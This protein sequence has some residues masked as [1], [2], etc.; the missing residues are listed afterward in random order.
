MLVTPEASTP[1]TPTSRRPRRPNARPK[2]ER[3]RVLVG[4]RRPEVVGAAAGRCCGGGGGCRA[5]VC[6]DGGE[7]EPE[8]VVET[9]AAL[10]DVA[11]DNAGRRAHVSSAGRD[12]DGVV[13]CWGGWAFVC[14]ASASS[15]QARGRWAGRL[16]A[17]ARMHYVYMCIYVQSR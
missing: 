4:A 3:A 11:P 5:E 10:V 7:E 14:I 1:I 13:L 15:S 2:A 8:G 17:A 16:A 6:Y 12:C 9:L